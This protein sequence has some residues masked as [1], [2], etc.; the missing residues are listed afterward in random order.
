VASIMLSTGEDILKDFAL[1]DDLLDKWAT[2][3]PEEVIDADAKLKEEAKRKKMAQTRP[4]DAHCET[5]LDKLLAIYPELEL[6]GSF[7]WSLKL[8]RLVEMTQYKPS[9]R[10]ILLRPS[11]LPA[12]LDELA[13]ITLV[14]KHMSAACFDEMINHIGTWA[15]ENPDKL[16]EILAKTESEATSDFDAIMGENGDDDHTL[17]FKAQEDQREGLD[18]THPDWGE[19]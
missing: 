2:L 1:N 10:T 17:A 4:T 19:W 9:S 3:S 5:E 11:S 12:D 6:P 14:Q 7:H 18:Q 15:S 8:V 13:P 16:E